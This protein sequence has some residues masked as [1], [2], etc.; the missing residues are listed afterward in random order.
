MNEVII[1][2]LIVGGGDRYDNNNNNNINNN[3]VRECSRDNV[4]GRDLVRESNSDL[5]T[6]G[7]GTAADTSNSVTKHNKL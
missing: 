1:P 5:M 7:T 2:T 4:R 6:T 3:H